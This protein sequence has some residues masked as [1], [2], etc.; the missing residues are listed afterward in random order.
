MT[1]QGFTRYEVTRLPSGFYQIVA[2][3]NGV[4]Q[5][6][7]YTGEH[8]YSAHLIASLRAVAEA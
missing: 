4:T 5:R 1:P 8:P 6:G 2:E 7:T 3:I